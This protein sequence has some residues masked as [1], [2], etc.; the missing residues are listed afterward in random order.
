MYKICCMVMKIGRDDVHIASSKID[1]LLPDS[2]CLSWHLLRVVLQITPFTPTWN[3]YNHVYKSLNVPHPPSNQAFGWKD[4]SYRTCSFLPSM[5]IRALDFFSIPPVCEDEIE[6]KTHAASHARQRLVITIACTLSLYT[7]KKICFLTALKLQGKSSYRPRL[8]WDL[9]EGSNKPWPLKMH[10]VVR[11]YTHHSF[12]LF[13]YL[14]S[15]NSFLSYIAFLS[16][17]EERRKQKK[18]L[19][20]SSQKCD[21][22]MASE[23]PFKVNDCKQDPRLLT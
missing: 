17:W 21:I 1:A 23:L 12:S 5:T 19:L 15:L 2:H 4:G 18:Q 13:P 14:V 11:R 8:F 6:N 7:S 3:N 22:A 10:N 9:P 20:Q 16:D